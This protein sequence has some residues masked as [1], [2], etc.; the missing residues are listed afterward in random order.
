MNTQTQT[1]WKTLPL[2]LLLLVFTT[3]SM[4]GDKARSK[5]PTITEIAETTEGFGILYAALEAAGLDAT[6]D[7][8]RHFTV[9][10]P[11][12]EAFEQLLL[13]L[14]LTAGDLLANTELLTTVL[15][16]HVTRGDRYSGSV[17]AAGALKMLDGN[18]TSVSV[19][20]EGPMIDDAVITATDIR[21]SNGVI[22]VINKVII[23]PGL[24]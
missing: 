15:S 13:D 23:P 18:M 3:G 4:A 17:L 5:L 9:F 24:M 19:T 12:D 1:C 14:G 20:S 2:M 16:Y 21:A 7:G 6:F 10:A 11:T 22:H 8:K